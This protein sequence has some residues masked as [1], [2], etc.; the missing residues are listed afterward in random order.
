MRVTFDAD[1]RG[2]GAGRPP[3]DGVIIATQMGSTAYSFAGGGPL[4]SAHAHGMIATHDA[5]HGLLNRA[6]VLA[7][8]ESLGIEVLRSGPAV[9][10]R[11]AGQLP[12]RAPA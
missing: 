5:P 7:D 11:I 9:R 10:H 12:A 8:G 1:H 4:V 6:V 3:C 2:P